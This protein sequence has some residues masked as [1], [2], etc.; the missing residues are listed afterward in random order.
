M[1][2]FTFTRHERR[3]VVALCLVLA[4]AWLLPFLSDRRRMAPEGLDAMRTT[5]RGVDT[6]NRDQGSGD[7]K[8][9]RVWNQRDRRVDPP[10]KP[11]DR[12]FPFDPNAASESE[13]MRLGLNSRQARIIRN[14]VSKGG[15]F[16]RAEDLLR[17]YGFPEEALDVLAPHVR[18]HPSV[19]ETSHDAYKGRPLAGP[20]RERSPRRIGKI[21]INS[22]DSSAWESLPGIGPVLASRIVKFRERLGG[23]HSASQVA[24]TYGLP[25]SVYLL[26]RPLLLEEPQ[27]FSPVLD[28]NAATVAEMRSHPYMTPRLARSVVAYRE[29]HGRYGRV[30]DLLAIETMTG[31][32]VE[33]L[34]PYILIR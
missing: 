18:I 11:P 14:Y 23:F 20:S 22:A 8:R 19:R 30:E 28:I 2:L 27:N 7:A 25:D 29:Q 15:R 32:L 33:K 34:K 21:G 5:L 24:E 6:V 3:G 13:W 1:A 4:L 12:V 10:F 31:E 26:I 17:V 9:G 16:R